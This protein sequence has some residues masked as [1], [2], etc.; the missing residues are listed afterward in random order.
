M[1]PPSDLNTT[2][3]ALS[4]PENTNRALQPRPVSIHPVAVAHTPPGL[5]TPP[6]VFSLLKALRRRLGP[7]LFLGLV[8]ASAVGATVWFLMPPPK[9]AARMKLHVAPNQPMVLFPDKD[10][11][12]VSAGMFIRSQAELIRDRYIIVAA[13]RDPAVN[14][15][16]MLQEQEDPAQWLEEKLAVEVSNPEYITISLS[17]DQKEELVKIVAAVTKAYME[18]FANKEQSDRK[19][20]LAKIE[21]RKKEFERK[22]EQLKLN[23]QAKQQVAGGIDADSVILVQQLSL[24]ELQDIKRNLRKVHERLLA[25]SVE[26]GL[27]PDWEDKSGPASDQLVQLQSVVG[28]PSQPLVNS[29]VSLALVALFRD[30]NL[31]ASYNALPVSENELDAWIDKEQE[32]K[33]GM[34]AVQKL[35]AK[36]AAMHEKLQPN[37]FRVQ[38]KEVQQEIEALENQIEERRKSLR[39]NAIKELRHRMIANAQGDR[40]TKVRNYSV[41]KMMEARLIEKAEELSKKCDQ[42]IKQAA[43]LSQWLSDI[44][45]VK[46]VVDK[47]TDKINSMDMEQEAPPR[48]TPLYDT[49]VLFTPNTTKRK[50]MISGGA[51]LAALLVVMLAFSWFEFQTRKVH[52]PDEVVQQLGLRLVGTVPDHSPRGWLPWSRGRENDSHYT[53]SMLTESVDTARTMLLHVARQDKI[54]IVMITSALSGEGKTSL[55]SHLAASLARAGRRTILVDSDLRNPTLHRLFERNRAPGLSELLRS[56]VDLASVIGE[57][58]I[59]NLWLIPA[60]KADSIALQTLAFDVVPKLFE[61]LR[62]HYD[63]VIV[64]SCPILPV[65]D[66][67]LVGQHVDAVIFSLLREVSRMPR[68]YAAYQRLSSLGIRMLGAVVNGTQHERYPSDYHYVVQDSE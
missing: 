20:R 64:D 62:L 58:T 9:I 16:S 68:V 63:F 61:R 48:I 1:T 54:Q 27:P 59:P 57:T 26:M 11:G 60:G 19:E 22:S 21:L 44:N 43:D 55:A 34:E 65:T 13:L 50:L 24:E 10:S 28:L 66:S 14:S 53:Q 35:K 47:A 8:L 2:S 5:N 39:E 51:A 32:I 45:S 7:A 52:T 30:A 4:P 15:L 6:N 37:K 56:E 31:F 12:S 36:H 3:S 46:K 41:L 40:T 17:G 42:K 25:L 33:K 38:G 23:V 49:P 67:M 29:S 18:K